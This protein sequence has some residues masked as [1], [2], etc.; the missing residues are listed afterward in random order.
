[1]IFNFQQRNP[2]LTGLGFAFWQ[3]SDGSEFCYCCGKLESS[4]SIDN[5]FICAIMRTN[6]Q[7]L[8]M[9]RFLAFGGRDLPPFLSIFILDY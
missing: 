5:I 7:V 4:K 1:V 9:A 8:I 2:W 6:S 3:E